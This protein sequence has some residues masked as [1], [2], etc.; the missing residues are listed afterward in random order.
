MTPDQIATL[1]GQ[2]FHFRATA[3]GEVR[4][5]EGEEAQWTADQEALASQPAPRR[6]IPKS[7]IHERVND[8]GKL[9]AVLTALRAEGQ[10]INYARWFSP[11]WPNVYFDDPA[12]LTLLSEVGC[13]E[14]EIATITAA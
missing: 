7:V 14:G 3:G 5:T 8:I 10:E 1:K 11:D 6:L 13:T 12:M 2:G 4:F 9:G